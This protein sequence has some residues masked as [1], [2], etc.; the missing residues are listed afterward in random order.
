MEILKAKRLHIFMRIT[1]EPSIQPRGRPRDLP[2]P[3]PPA[4]VASVL[5]F[6]MLLVGL[7]PHIKGAHGSKIHVAW[8]KH[9]SKEI[10][11]SYERCK[12]GPHG[13]AGLTAKVANGCRVSYIKILLLLGGC[14]H[15][16][17]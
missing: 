6:A 16:R 7:G 3:S 5:A 13:G 11:H 8:L 15:Q 17:A 10:Y 14:L 12:F 1:R 2:N 4:I 9:M